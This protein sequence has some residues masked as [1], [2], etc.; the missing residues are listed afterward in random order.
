M[1]EVLPRRSTRVVHVGKA[2]I[3][4]PFPVAVQSMCATR[5]RDVDATVAQC[6]QL[7]RAGAAVVRIAVDNEKEVEAL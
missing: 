5:T 4:G 2:R 7:R 1:S 6:E 3:G